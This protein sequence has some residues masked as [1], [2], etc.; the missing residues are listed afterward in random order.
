ML[1]DRSHTACVITRYSSQPVQKLFCLFL[2]LSAKSVAPNLTLV[3]GTML[4]LLELLCLLVL[5]P[6]YSNTVTLT[7][8]ATNGDPCREAKSLEPLITVGL[9]DGAGK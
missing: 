4:T 2:L 1:L 5:A 9:I 3:S 8:A 7:G 6:I